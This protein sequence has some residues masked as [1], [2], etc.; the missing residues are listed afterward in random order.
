MIQRLEKT[1]KENEHEWE[2]E[3]ETNRID[4]KLYYTAVPIE[5]SEGGSKASPVRRLSEK[6]CVRFT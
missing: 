5:T 3:R 6:H 2:K 4:E 1:R